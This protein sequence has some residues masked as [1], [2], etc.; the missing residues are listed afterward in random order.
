MYCKFYVTYER[1]CWKEMIDDYRKMVDKRIHLR[2]CGQCGLKDNVEVY[3]HY[4]IF[5]ASNITILWYLST[6]ETFIIT[7]NDISTVTQLLGN[8]ESYAKLAQDSS[9]PKNCAKVTFFRNCIILQ[10][11]YLFCMYLTQRVLVLA[12]KVIVVCL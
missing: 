11:F 3:T 2:F 10:P 9:C 4:P 12:V 7:W 6:R 5:V 1:W 8:F